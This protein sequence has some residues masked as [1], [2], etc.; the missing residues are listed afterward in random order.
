MSS[1][2]CLFTIGFGYM[3]IE[4]LSNYNKCESTHHKAPGAM[5]I[6]LIVCLPLV[7]RGSAM[8]HSITLMSDMHTDDI[9]LLPVPPATLQRWCLALPFLIAMKL[10]GST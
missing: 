6:C 3:E 7:I 4:V 9:V 10:D 8:W 5:G 2:G 1:K